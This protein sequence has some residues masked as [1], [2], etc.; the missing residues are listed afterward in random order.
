MKTKITYVLASIIFSFALS[1]CGNSNQDNTAETLAMHTE[2]NE[3]KSNTAV[4]VMT[5]SETEFDFG[6]VAEGDIL[7]HTF[8]FTNTGN[9]PLVIVNAK[10]SCGCTVSNW[11]KEPIA[12]GAT[13]EMLVTF[14]TN[15]KPNLQNK[16]VTITTNAA[17]GK[18]ILK[19]KAMVTP[20]IKNT[21]SG[22]PLSK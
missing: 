18:Q 17:T 19:I 1:S 7:E 5:F 22:I 10:G 4:A 6:T 13:E 20:K 21:I 3:Q 14:N 12:P 11:P 2:P 8:S 15:G 16:Q 9:A